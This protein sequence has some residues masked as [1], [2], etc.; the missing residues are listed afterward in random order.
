MTWGSNPLSGWVCDVDA[1]SHGHVCLSWGLMAT[2]VPAGSNVSLG[3][4]CRGER[5]ETSPMQWC[6]G[7]GRE[8]VQQCPGLFFGAAVKSPG[9]RVG[10]RHGRHGCISH[11]RFQLQAQQECL[12]L[13]QTHLPLT[14][15]APA[16]TQGNS[17]KPSGPQVFHRIK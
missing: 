16:E 3:E 14:G 7:K 2:S 15:Q 11:F 9:M 4:T 10:I 13:V 6:S 1:F 12:V 8:G 5:V 17:L